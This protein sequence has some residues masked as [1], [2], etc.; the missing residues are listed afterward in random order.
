MLDIG[1]M[2]IDNFLRIVPRNFWNWFTDQSRTETRTLLSV[3]AKKWSDQVLV[4][5]GMARTARSTTWG[6]RWAACGRSYTCMPILTTEE[7]RL[8]PSLCPYLHQQ[9]AQVIFAD[10]ITHAP[11]GIIPVIILDQLHLA[12]GKQQGQKLGMAEFLPEHEFHLA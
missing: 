4:Y 2:F 5:S 11:K 3:Q 7:I 10:P 12:G 8:S 9:L 6:M 1:G